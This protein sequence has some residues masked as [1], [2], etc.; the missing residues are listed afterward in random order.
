MDF[1]DIVQT[2]DQAPPEQPPEM[3]KKP[4]W[5]V[6]DEHAKASVQEPELAKLTVPQFA[7]KMN[8]VTGTNSYD[9]GLSSNW[10]RQAGANIERGLR[11]FGGA[12][13][14]TWPAGAPSLAETLGGTREGFDVPAAA[15]ELGKST[16]TS[17]GAGPELAE[18]IG[19][20][21]ESLPKTGLTVGVGAALG[22]L[23]TIAALSGLETYGET[24]RVLPSLVS[25]GTAYAIP[26]AM[27]VGGQAALRALGAKTVGEIRPELAA[28]MDKTLPSTAETLSKY[29]PA[30]GWSPTALAQRGAR[31][32]GAQVGMLGAGLAGEAAQTAINPDLTWQEKL[33]AVGEEFSPS[34][35]VATAVGQLPFT[36][37]DIF[38]EKTHPLTQVE[39]ATK[40]D[41]A[42]R[43]KTA[44]MKGDPETG[45]PPFIPT[46]D[47]INKVIQGLTTG[48]IEPDSP[49][50][51]ILQSIG[52]LP[53][54][55][56]MKTPVMTSEAAW[57]MPE[58]L[59]ATRVRT[60]E[61]LI[62]QGATKEI[63]DT[64]D[65]TIYEALR[66]AET[67]SGGKAS[68]DDMLQ[69]VS[70]RV[71]D[72]YWV[73]QK[74]MDDLGTAP[75]KPTS[76][77]TSVARQ[78]K[79]MPEIND[80][81]NP[82]SPN[83][84][85]E[86]HQ[87]VALATGDPEH[88][89]EAGIT[90]PVNFN[91]Q[92][93]AIPLRRNVVEDY[94]GLPAKQ[95]L[96]PTVVEEMNQRRQ[97]WDEM[98]EQAREFDASLPTA[99][100]RTP[101]QNQQL[102][103]ML[104]HAEFL[105]GEVQRLRGELEGSRTRS[106]P[107]TA[108]ATQEAVIRAY[109]YGK[110]PADQAA[111]RVLDLKDPH[112]VERFM[113]DIK[114]KMKLSELDATRERGP[115]K[116]YAEYDTPTE[117]EAAASE[118][119][120]LGAETTEGD[121]HSTY[122]VVKDN[123]GNPIP[124]KD[125]K[126]QVIEQS[127]YNFRPIFERTDTGTLEEAL[128]GAV[129]EPEVPLA[130]PMTLDEMGHDI[131]AL[132]NNM[133]SA[134]MNALGKLS[135]PAEVSARKMALTNNVAYFLNHM[136]DATFRKTLLSFAA[137]MGREETTVAGVARLKQ[138]MTRY[139]GFL[140]DGGQINT[141]ERNGRI[142]GGPPEALA[143]LNQYMGD[144]GFGNYKAD[145]KVVTRQGKP[146]V[147]E[148]NRPK[149]VGLNFFE[150][151]A[152]LMDTM[153]K[154]MVDPR[155]YADAP[156]TLPKGNFGF[157]PPGFREEAAR[158]LLIKWGPE[159]NQGLIGAPPTTLEGY[160]LTK[161]GKLAVYD[162][163]G[164]PVQF[165]WVKR[166]PLMTFF[167]ES[168]KRDLVMPLG[169]LLD[170]FENHGVLS[171]QN[172]TMLALARKLA[173]NSA[174]MRDM[175]VGVNAAKDPNQKGFYHSDHVASSAGILLSPFDLPSYT[176]GGGRFVRNLM[177]PDAIFP[178][179]MNEIG[180]TATDF[181]YLKDDVF[182]KE[183]DKV[184]QYVNEHVKA[185]QGVTGKTSEFTQTPL[186]AL[187]DPREFLGSMFNDHRL[188][189]LLQ[190]IADPFEPLPGMQTQG[191]YVGSLFNRIM[192][193]IRNMMTN[194]FGVGS[195]EAQ[196]MLNRMSE[197]TSRGF[198]IQSRMNL[199][200]RG[201]IYEQALQRNLIGGGILE[202][203]PPFREIKITGEGVPWA[204]TAREAPPP[205]PGPLRPEIVP[206]ESAAQEQLSQ[207]QMNVQWVKAQHQADPIAYTTEDIATAEK[208]LQIAQNR[209]AA[210][211]VPAN[212][213]FVIR[214]HES[215]L[216]DAQSMLARA[217]KYGEMFPG[218]ISQAQGQIA[219]ETAT[220]EGLRRQQQLKGSMLESREAQPQDTV[221]KLG[222]DRV[223]WGKTSDLVGA[224]L[225]TFTFTSPDLV[226][227]RDVTGGNRNFKTPGG[228]LGL[229]YTQSK[230]VAEMYQ[231]GYSNAFNRE[232]VEHTLNPQANGFLTAEDTT[233]LLDK[234][235]LM[236]TKDSLKIQDSDKPETFYPIAD[237]LLAKYFKDRGFDYY[238]R[239]DG[240][241]GAD[242]EFVILTENAVKGGGSVLESRA[243]GQAMLDSMKSAAVYLHED[244]ERIW[245][246]P[247]DP[248]YFRDTYGPAFGF[249]LQL[250][251]R[252]AEVGYSVDKRAL[253]GLTSYDLSLMPKPDVRPWTPSL[254]ETLSSMFRDQ[255]SSQETSNALAS[256]MLQ[257]GALL[258]DTDRAVWGKIPSENKENTI[259][260]KA[261]GW[262]RVA[263][264]TPEATEQLTGV[265]PI[266]YTIKHE[267]AHLAGLH[268]NVEAEPPD[269]REAHD[270][271]NEVFESLDPEGRKAFLEGLGS[272]TVADGVYPGVYQKALVNPVEF[273]AEFMGHVGDVIANVPKPSAYLRDEMRFVPDE[274][275]R[276]LIKNTL[277]RTQGLD[278]LVR[279][280]ENA[281]RAREITNKDWQ[282]MVSDV[283]DAFKPLARSALDIATDQAEFYRMR[284]LYPDMYK[285]L[286]GAMSQSLA[287]FQAYRPEET[288]PTLPGSILMSMDGIPNTVRRFFKLP[289]SS[290]K[291]PDKLSWWDKFLTNFSQFADKYPEARSAWDMFFNGRALYNNFR[292]KMTTA[293]AGAFEGNKA[294]D[295]ARTKAVHDFMN[296]PDLR[297]A[298]S[299]IALELN[300][301]GDHLFDE[302][303]ASQKG[304]VMTMNPQIV[305]G[306]LTPEWIKGALRKYGV[307][308]K[309]VP[310]MM[311]VLDGTRN[312]VKMAQA[313]ILGSSIH[314]MDTAMAVAVARN[315]DLAPEASRKAAQLLT[316]AVK[317]QATDFDGAMA[318]L[319]EFRQIV[320][321]P[322][323]FQRMFDA[324]S[325]AWEGIQKLERYL[326][327]RMPYYM[328]ERRPGQ[329]GLFF[330][331]PA[332]KVTSRYFRNQN[333]RNQYIIS[334][335][336]DPVRQTNPGDKDWGISPQIFKQ[337]DDVHARMTEKL[338]NLFGEDEGE[339]LAATMDMASELRDALNSRDVLRL[340]TGRDLAPGRE[341]LDMFSAHQQYVN[342]IGK[343]SYNTFLRLE[344]ELLNTAA[345]LDN[346][347]AIKDFINKQVKQVMLPDS[348]IGRQAQNLS[349][350]Y[351]LWGN[352]SSMIMQS[353]HQVMGL[354]PMLT[355]RG[356]S[357]AGSFGAIVKA[358]QLL[359]DS[360]FGGR[361]K[362]PEIQSAVE[363]ARKDGTL[364]S[365]IARE[366]DIGQ[367]QSMIN[368]MRATTG[369][370]LWAPFDML[371]NRLYQGYD[372]IRRMYDVVPVYNSE[373]ALVASLLHLKSKA[374]GSLS[375][376]TLYKEAQFLRSITMFT[377]GKENRPGFFQALP[378][379]AA[380][381]MWSLQTYANGLT[382]MMGELIRRSTNP[383]GMT[384]AQTKQ[385]RY[386][387]AQMLITQTA[388]AGVLG[389]PFA[390][391]LLYAVQ[392]IFPEH[393]I[394]QDVRDALA[395]LFG[396]DE[397]MGHAFSSI[398]TAGVP[399]SLDYS[400]D[401]GSRFALAGTF[402]VSP[403]SGVGWEQLVG[404]T[405]GILSRA[406]EGAQAG[407]RGD[408]LG[409]VKNLMPNGFQRIWKALEQGKTY[410]TSSGQMVVSDLRPEE[411]VARIIGFG[412]SRVAR[413]EDYERLS[414]VSEDAEKAEQTRWTKEQ[415]QLMM[416]GQDAQVQQ[417]V[418]QRV[419]E[420]KGTFPAQQLS[421]DISRE[422]ERATMPANLRAFGN[423]STVLAQKS[424][425]GVLGTQD[426]GPS[427]VERLQLQQTIAGRL[428]LGGP[429]RGSLKHAAGVD[430]LLSMYP[431]LTNAQANL[432]L[433]HAAASRPSPELYS[434][435]LGAPE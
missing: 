205:Q 68:R 328:S 352:L 334:K 251:P 402:H 331:D 33:K 391:A 384:P 351:Y 197:L 60:K 117:A 126:Y 85:R 262:H 130:G 326:E 400:P 129:G 90:E 414:R 22:G 387:A 127:Y 247:Y 422:Y 424:L 373:V 338:K 359:I 164:N 298:F 335:N 315:T 435:L 325:T 255:G 208:A 307:A 188:H 428:G 56:D 17:F 243:D 150:Q 2:P 380:Q 250:E 48:K 355:S 108:R 245:F 371:K 69:A 9:E 210:G 145:D 21:A 20:A 242:P 37:F 288:T 396:D 1:S 109:N 16:A 104:N 200:H 141:F 430:Q 63:G 49:M 45:S 169:Q 140:R 38:N 256:Q 420:K 272:V 81:I 128:E 329:F 220:L 161:G 304:D 180:H 323:A 172:K 52:Q 309:D 366:L 116:L 221:D 44:A 36:A 218:L 392:K 231:K 186:H 168:A 259:L 102:E 184:F 327:L 207:A 120:K 173:N 368:R 409:T 367:D 7:Q 55:P 379:S 312:Q 88:W 346:Q 434:E 425:R 71:A 432:L 319:D 300:T 76:E 139:L 8:E 170:L 98:K 183:V 280:V 398:M 91:R 62:A 195:P 238:T 31:L 57:P 267:G 415:V 6:L 148:W 159:L 253:D 354:A 214:N 119:E 118:A 317:T 266:D 105:K 264:I 249:K 124:T 401:F 84:D 372:L 14:G 156:E 125:G 240:N 236:S 339:K 25:A 23:P 213:S 418:A 95:G 138:R 206:P 143:A 134:R 107:V 11:H 399:S 276:L 417:N 10:I 64:Y 344:T 302:E 202:R 350:L 279:L 175:P 77:A 219:K 233:T 332:G 412:P 390:Q 209:L 301:F 167:V 163:Q 103:E 212:I 179:F 296:R 408:P 106:R 132:A 347:P 66:A 303:L 341:E 189:Q 426:E 3:Q 198:D 411:V 365:W 93:K 94:T 321:S 285:G 235:G 178:H 24:G 122:S 135:D 67:A 51:H 260:G 136:S 254:F 230:P 75:T 39:N 283:S 277:R 333:E 34:S 393:N 342:S 50:G 160:P 269:V 174:F 404:P 229:F 224:K 65:Q 227:A 353:S 111:G 201:D 78:V 429:S 377:G 290:G 4:Y 96:E 215:R 87:R 416:S 165:S 246:K 74:A 182:R 80:V 42:Q 187:S 61:L 381:A 362:D 374:G 268:S 433:T 154:Q 13:P 191:G 15:H 131:D 376:E 369:K 289:D 313:T 284:N 395:G 239:D 92:G 286:L 407:L 204:P 419:A 248:T 330:K 281:A 226:R 115:Q 142:V 294:A 203:P 47:Q 133:I 383:K 58:A 258:K 291:L 29:A 101:A 97:Q 223:K 225:P 228:E 100:E 232:L 275:S 386:A 166:N 306:W 194:L 427:N 337:L 410:Q 146:R 361:Y 43:L 345:D 158:S 53:M 343:A 375:G 12:A 110:S 263:G 308:D 35:L 261:W 405:G 193:M 153:R 265:R 211:E 27:E 18:K 237:K 112:S 324:A 336:I 293:L 19:G 282:G 137:R 114:H 216:A 363:R 292:I 394:E 358:N 273:A 113:N 190:G 149:N 241:M 378:R 299:E 314:R 28:L 192:V 397:Q 274:M 82:E 199:Q 177:T 30:T 123:Q 356:A 79:L 222:E 370:G 155:V 217:S 305:T 357:V 46:V 431:H 322:Q 349:F 54:L 144:L 83:Y 89:I 86:A 340:T 421:N 270:R 72:K 244:P 73:D 318:K 5:Q 297:K 59:S 348:P 181:A 176:E 252:G 311:T 257:F 147:E 423:R 388:V 310:T 151:F 40:A 41:F 406:F 99:E 320:K 413:I 271:V 26:K 295:D 70:S 162:R 171:D 196:T 234:L 185:L 385:T 403:Y 382:T 389:M 32:G 287:E 316:D 157:V 360:K 121:W 278:R 152:V 364:G